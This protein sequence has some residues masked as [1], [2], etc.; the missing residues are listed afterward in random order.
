MA[1]AVQ[2]SHNQN[3]N[4]S[5]G[6][7]TNEEANRLGRIWVGDGA[8]P[9][10]DGKGLISADGLRVYRPSV[11]KPNTPAQYNPTGKQANFEKYENKTISQKVNGKWETK[12]Q[13]VKIGNG[14]LNITD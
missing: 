6:G 9:T 8:K 1:K 14:H 4:Y 2:G 11:I 5:I 3:I 7:G 13:R 12:I 10:S